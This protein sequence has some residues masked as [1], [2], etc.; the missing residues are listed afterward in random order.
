MVPGYIRENKQLK[1]FEMLWFND[2]L[3]TFKANNYDVQYT[4][5]NFLATKQNDITTQFKVK[6][7][8]KSVLV[9]IP[10]SKNTEYT[11]EFTD[12]WKATEFVLYHLKQQVS[13]I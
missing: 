5:N 4:N 7:V 12:Y 3:E 13:Q 1:T 11:T 9:T 8:N 10:F 2:V 6:T